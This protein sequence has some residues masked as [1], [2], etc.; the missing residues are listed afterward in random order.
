MQLID[1]PPLPHLLRLP[2]RILHN[3]AGGKRIVDKPS[4][5]RR[6]VRI[7]T[8]H[9]HDGFGEFRAVDVL[10]HVPARPR[11]DES[12][13]VFRCIRH[14]QRQVLRARRLRNHG[15]AT[16]VRHVYVQEN[17]VGLRLRDTSNGLGD[18]AGIADDVNRRSPRISTSQLGAD[19]GAEDGVIVNKK[20]ANWLHDLDFTAA[21]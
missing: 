18:G 12:D 6:E 7:P 11:T 20:N 15:E 13:D 3:P 14:R 5:A 9:L 4:E 8:M 1:D 19:A 10:R 17:N 21:T 16:A 2:R